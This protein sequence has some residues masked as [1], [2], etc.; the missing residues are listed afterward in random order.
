MSTLLDKR[1]SRYAK[2][3]LAALIDAP[4]GHGNAAGSYIPYRRYEMSFP[5]EQMPEPV[6]KYTDLVAGR[7][8]PKEFHKGSEI[9]EMAYAISEAIGQVFEGTGAQFAVE[10]VVDPD[11]RGLGH[12]VNF[13]LYSES[14]GS[15]REL[16]GYLKTNRQQL[17]TKLASLTEGKGGD[18]P[19]H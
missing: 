7:I 2:D 6:G 8:S 4:T 13:F 15:E 18:L 5:E 1:Y 9:H 3:I 16:S 19:K 11:G 17:L 12:N 10:A 14:H